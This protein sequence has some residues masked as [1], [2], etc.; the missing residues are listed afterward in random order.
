M[1][2]D[3]NKQAQFFPFHGI[4]EY[5]LP[6][7]RLHVLQAVFNGFDRLPGERRSA[8]NGLVKKNVQVPGFRN[9]TQA[10]AGV[11]ARAAVATFERRPD[12]VAQVLQGWSELHPEL[13]QKVYDFLK[14]REWEVLPPEADRSKL[15]GFLIEWPKEQD[16]DVLGKAFQEMYPDFTHE[17]NDLRLMIVWLA[18]RL[19]VDMYEDEEEDEEEA[20]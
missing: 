6:D 4:N 10:P 7:F 3:N 19:P 11:K 16:Y 14:A 8:I 9:S 13:R 20:E 12:F 2:M 1:S 5:M 18:D 15:P 17:E